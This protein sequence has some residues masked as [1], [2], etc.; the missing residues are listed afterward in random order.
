MAAPIQYTR[1]IAA[2]YVRAPFENQSDEAVSTLQAFLHFIK[3][4][5]C[6]EPRPYKFLLENGQ[7]FF[8]KSEKPN[9]CLDIEHAVHMMLEADPIELE[10][11]CYENLLCLPD[12]HPLESITNSYFLDKFPI[13]T[14]NSIPHRLQPLLNTEKPA[15]LLFCTYVTHMIGFIAAAQHQASMAYAQRLLWLRGVCR[16]FAGGQLSCQETRIVCKGLISAPEPLQISITKVFRNQPLSHL[17]LFESLAKGDLI[18]LQSPFLNYM[19]MVADH[20]PWAA[21]NL[22]GWA[23]KAKMVEEAHLV[24][25]QFISPSQHPLR[26]DQN[27]A[28]AQQ[29]V[30]EALKHIL[31][32]LNANKGH[33]TAAPLVSKAYSMC[34]KS[35]QSITQ[36]NDLQAYKNEWQDMVIC[37]LRMQNPDELHALQ[38]FYAEC[39]SEAFNKRLVSEINREEISAPM[40]EALKIFFCQAPTGSLPQADTK[41]ALIKICKPLI[42]AKPQLESITSLLKQYSIDEPRIWLLLS[43]AIASYGDKRLDAQAGMNLFELSLDQKDDREQLRKDLKKI[44]VRNAW[45]EKYQ[46][47]C[48]ETAENHPQTLVDFFIDCLNYGKG[49]QAEEK[50]DYLAAL[51]KIGNSHDNWAKHVTASRQSLSYKPLYYICAKI[52]LEVEKDPSTVLLTY[53]LLTESW[54]QAAKQELFTLLCDMLLKRNAAV[55]NIETASAILKEDVIHS[56]KENA[57]LGLLKKAIMAI[58]PAADADVSNCQAILF[59][60]LRAILNNDIVAGQTA[61]TLSEI[62]QHENTKCLLGK[63]L[64]NIKIRHSFL[65]MRQAYIEEKDP[66]RQVEILW[67]YFATIKSSQLQIP[68]QFVIDQVRQLLTR[69]KQTDAAFELLLKLSVELIKHPRIKAEP[70]LVAD[71]CEALSECLLFHPHHQI[72]WKTVEETLIPLIKEKSLAQ[73]RLNLIV[74][75]CLCSLE[76]HPPVLRSRILKAAVQAGY[77]QKSNTDVQ[78][79]VLHL[80]FNGRMP[81]NI[82]V[83]VEKF[84][85]AI[86]Y[87]KQLKKELANFKDSLEKNSLLGVQQAKIIEKAKKRAKNIQAFNKFYQKMKA[88]ETEAGAE[89]KKIGIGQAYTYLQNSWFLHTD[90]I[91]N[92][93]TAILQACRQHPEEQAFFLEKYNQLAGSICQAITKSKGHNANYLILQQKLLDLLK[94]QPRRKSLPHLEAVTKQLLTYIDQVSRMPATYTEIKAKLASERKAL[95]QA[96][97]NYSHKLK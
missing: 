64:Q 24:L 12:T 1:H 95:T 50:T 52:V 8:I 6:I 36:P 68:F 10:Q 2:T 72:L 88:L 16:F 77:Y 48:S 60:A 93:A 25:L 82:S 67:Q 61:T 63:E 76:P 65:Q 7:L 21:A 31:Q 13:D 97:D 14:L 62:L 19:C 57:A 32:L 81:N 74:R 54:P 11:Q 42:S 4:P 80:L 75:L 37:A 79:T 44:A 56:E 40:A 33:E 83:P 38:P 28:A 90:P 35:L 9:R 87:S 23:A 91:R 78:Y 3:L 15:T 86:A 96:F 20:F 30:R 49:L 73:D 18:A 43:K 46:Q 27:Q 69:A 66:S 41:G 53:E 71:I 5:T 84:D 89:Q 85:E 47:Y 58:Q 55:W 94:L 26:F 22:I 51:E 17:A 70:S 92:F 39:H 34:K 29:T 45:V 59:E